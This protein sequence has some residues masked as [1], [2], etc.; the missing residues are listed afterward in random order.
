MEVF[1]KPDTLFWIAKPGLRVNGPTTPGPW[2]HSVEEEGSFDPV[3]SPK[4]QRWTAFLLFTGAH[5]TG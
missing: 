4:A 1:A 3:Y 5:K 2:P